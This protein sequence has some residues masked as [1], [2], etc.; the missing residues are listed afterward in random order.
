MKEASLFKISALSL[1]FSIGSKFIVE[2][3]FFCK[4]EITISRNAD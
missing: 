4:A 1:L 2:K 3:F